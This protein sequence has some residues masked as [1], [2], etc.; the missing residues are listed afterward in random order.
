[1]EIG[2]KISTQPR[3]EEINIDLGSK[4]REEVRTCAPERELGSGGRIMWVEI[5]PGE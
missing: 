4:E 5:L 2:R 1:M 3:L